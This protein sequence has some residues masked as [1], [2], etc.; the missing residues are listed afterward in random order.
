MP[1][2]RV[3]LT[4]DDVAHMLGVEKATVRKMVK[5]GEFP[6]PIK[7]GKLIRWRADRVKEYLLEIE[8]KQ[9]LKKER[10]VLRRLA[11]K[12]VVSQQTSEAGDLPSSTKKKPG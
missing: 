1:E 2:T 12:R 4:Y 7:I 10:V 6:E 9:R 5:T 3:L 8:I 11:S